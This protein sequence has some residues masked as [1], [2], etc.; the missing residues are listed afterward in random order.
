[1]NTTLLYLQ[2]T[3]FKQII[4]TWSNGDVSILHKFF[5]SEKRDERKVKTG[6]KGRHT[7]IWLT[8][9]GQ[10]RAHQSAWDLDEVHSPNLPACWGVPKSSM[11]KSLV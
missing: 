5:D 7:P 9:R 2:A 4:C 10:A 3:I 1:M 11:L 8:Y 6:I